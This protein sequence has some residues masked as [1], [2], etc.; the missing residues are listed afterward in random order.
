MLLLLLLTLISCQYASENF[1]GTTKYLKKPFA[2]LATFI[3]PTTTQPPG[4]LI[5]FTGFGSNFPASAYHDLLQQISQKANLV[6][7]AY[8]GLLHSNPLNQP[9]QLQTA[10]KILNYTKIG[11]EYDINMR[12]NFKKTLFGGH[13]SGNQLAVMMGL[14]Y[15][16]LGIVLVD[17]VDKD[18]CNLIK[19]VIT[20]NET[21]SYDKPVL[22]IGARRAMLKSGLLPPCSPVE[23]SSRH[24]YDAFKTNKVWLMVEDYGHFDLFGDRWASV[25][26]RV[27]FCASVLDVHKTPFEIFRGYIRGSVSLFLG[28]LEGRDC[29]A[30][31]DLLRSGGEL[32]KTVEF[33]GEICHDEYII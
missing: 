1:K 5:F 32:N 12:V 15:Y 28:A 17:P 19:Q 14:E 20:K 13:S 16:S 10:A 31:M 21:L 23:F 11:M 7:V 33:D 4:L 25:A 26:R 27:G 9:S 6:V 3:P 22:V 30:K 18:P 8:D 29:R 24:F 2:N